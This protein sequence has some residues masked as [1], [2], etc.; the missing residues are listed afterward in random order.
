MAVILAECDRGKRISSRVS[1][2]EIFAREKSS[3]R[4]AKKSPV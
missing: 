3:I 4:V 1:V 2:R